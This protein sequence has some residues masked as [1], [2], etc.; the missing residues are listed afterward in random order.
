M[1]PARGAGKGR[2]RAR[3]RRAPRSSPLHHRAGRGRARSARTLGV[4]IGVFFPTK[5]HGRLDETVARD[6]RGRRPGFLVG[7]AAAEHRLRRADGA[8]ARRARARRVS[9]WARRSS[10]PI[11]A[12]RSRSRRRRSPSTPPPTPGCCSG[13]GLSHRMADRGHVRDLLRPARAPHARVPRRV[14]A[15][16][17]TSGAVDVVRL[18]R[19][20]HAVAAH[21]RRGRRAD[22][23]ARRAAAADAR[24][25]RTAWRTAPSRGAPARSC[26][27]VRSSHSWARRPRCRPRRHRA[28]WWRCPRSSPTTKPTAG[29]RPANNSSGTATSPRTARCWISRAPRARPTCRWSATSGR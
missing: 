17:A 13:I 27:S 10:R 24:S 25:R 18:R 28:S 7:V 12:I 1:S 29:R 14:D 22:G 20:P 19:S 8:R 9:S 16:T 26:S 15:R 4:R 3:R 11:R 21:H 6:H 23:A 2:V 5:E